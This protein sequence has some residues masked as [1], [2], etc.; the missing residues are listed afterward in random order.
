MGKMKQIDECLHE[1]GLSI[2]AIGVAE[3][4]ADNLLESNPCTFTKIIQEEI[5]LVRLLA[6]NSWE[7]LYKLKKELET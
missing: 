1:F 4:L 6:N 3:V 2:Q 7:V 5:K